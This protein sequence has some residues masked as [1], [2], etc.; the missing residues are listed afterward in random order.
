MQIEVREAA[1]RVKNFVNS[2]TILRDGERYLPVDEDIMYQLLVELVI[3]NE[4]YYDFDNFRSR[5]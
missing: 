3:P 2:R 5:S 4:E 1:K